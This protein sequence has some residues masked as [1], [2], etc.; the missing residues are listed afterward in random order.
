MSDVCV[1]QF[2]RAHEKAILPTRAHGA[3]DSGYD[4]SS[5]A[6]SFY[7][8]PGERKLVSTGW[9]ISLPLGWEAQ[10][11]PR[12]GNA[13][14][15][16]ITVINTPG[17][18]DASY[19]GELGVILINLSNFPVL[20]EQGMKIAQ[21]VLTEIPASLV[22]EVDEFTPKDTTRGEKGYGSTGEKA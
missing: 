11:R 20:I 2:L 3:W 1:A 22:V 7:L 9:K 14:H 19:M 16:G 21:M 13:Y 15:K 10:I 12:S 8:A 6:D 4:L 5:V 17:T 18:I